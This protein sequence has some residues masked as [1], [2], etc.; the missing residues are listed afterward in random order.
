MKTVKTILPFR[1][2]KTGAIRSAGET[3]TV[4]DER[5]EQLKQNLP[6]GYIVIE[7]AP[8]PK[9]RKPRA[10]KTKAKELAKE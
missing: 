9:A 10:T 3:F 7:D 2:I 4:N 6:A 8:T 1:D 5:A